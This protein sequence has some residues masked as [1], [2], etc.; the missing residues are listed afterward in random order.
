MSGDKP[1]IQILLSYLWVDS[2]AP[3]ILVQ[4]VCYIVN[5][6]KSYIR[7]ATRHILHRNRL[8]KAYY[9]LQANIL[10]AQSDSFDNVI[11]PGSQDITSIDMF[12]QVIS[13]PVLQNLP[14]ETI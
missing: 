10:I 2:C 4:Y 5:G 12:Q 11:Y 9:I 13:I 7:K 3:D 6:H 1:D 8:A 14:A